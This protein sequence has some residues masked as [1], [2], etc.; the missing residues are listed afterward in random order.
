M[1]SLA[2]K[3]RRVR[4]ARGLSQQ[5]VADRSRMGRSSITQIE[6]GLRKKLR[7]D[8]FKALAAALSVEPVY[9]QTDDPR[10]YLRIR[11]ANLGTDE[12][13]QLTRMDPAQRWSWILAELETMWG[14]EWKQDAVAERLLISAKSFAAMMAGHVE[15]SAAVN[16]SLSDMT[17]V[18]FTFIA[19]ATLASTDQLME[20]Y[21]RALEL[22]QD[23]GI[24]P[25]RLE[26]AVRLM[27]ATETRA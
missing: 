6:Q 19:G 23:A 13:I 18:P 17:G 4:L 26:L 25:E 7:P 2:D 9:F 10:E 27:S 24:S 11:L 15:L 20:K 16:R 3:V 5:E 8:S 1:L 21:R 12:S 22:A 14:D